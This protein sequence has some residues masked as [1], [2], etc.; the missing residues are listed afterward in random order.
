[1]TMFIQNTSFL[2]GNLQKTHPF[3]QNSIACRHGSSRIPDIGQKKCPGFHMGLSGL[4]AR[5]K[6]RLQEY[7]VFSGIQDCMMWLSPVIERFV[8]VVAGK[9]CIK[10]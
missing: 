8:R 4:N 10:K 1:M 3:F 2:L 9:S 5:H 6:S 7:L